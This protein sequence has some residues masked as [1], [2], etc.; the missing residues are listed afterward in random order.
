MTVFAL[1]DVSFSSVIVFLDSLVE[2]FRDKVLKEAKPKNK[3]Y[4]DDFV[5]MDKDKEKKGK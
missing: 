1:L 3:E 5:K 2:S 4:K